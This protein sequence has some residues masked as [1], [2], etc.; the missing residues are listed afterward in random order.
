MQS[1]TVKLMT[2][3][4]LAVLLIAVVAATYVSAQPF[5]RH[6]HEIS[7]SQANTIALNRYPNGTLVGAT[8]M[9]NMNGRMA[10]RVAVRSYGVRHIVFVNARN[11]RIMSIQ[12]RPLGRGGGR[13]HMRYHRNY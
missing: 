2:R 8:R 9:I 4:L 1:R 6:R 3:Y 13:M 10:Y 5:F 11:G 7:I 12:D